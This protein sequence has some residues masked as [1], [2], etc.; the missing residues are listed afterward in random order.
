MILSA[1]RY[2]DI[3]K[4]VCRTVIEN[5]N[6]NITSIQT[7]SIS[8]NIQVES[9]VNNVTNINIST[10]LLNNAKNALDIII[11]G[12]GE[13]KDL[14]NIAKNSI[15]KIVESNPNLPSILLNKGKEA[16]KNIMQ[17]NQDP[18]DLLNIAKDTLKDIIKGNSNQT[19]NNSGNALNGNSN[20]PENTKDQSGN[21]IGGNTN[22]SAELLDNAKGAL[23]NIIKGNINNPKELLNG[24]KDVLV[25]ILKG[26]PNLPGYLVDTA[27]NALKD[28]IQGKAKPKDLL[29]IAKE[30]LKN[31]I[32]VIPKQP[33]NSLSETKNAQGNVVNINMNNPG[34]KAE[35]NK[36]NSKD[37]LNGIGI[38]TGN[39]N[40][41]E[42]DLSDVDSK[43][44]I[45]IVDNSN[46]EE[47]F[48]FVK[49]NIEEEKDCN[50]NNKKR[51]DIVNPILPTLPNGTVIDDPT[52]RKIDLNLK[53]DERSNYEDDADYYSNLIKPINNKSTQDR[54]RSKILFL[55]NLLIYFFNKKFMYLN[56]EYI[57]KI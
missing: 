45:P 32:L 39:T 20:E 56:L 51:D 10:E 3:R 30:A 53:I 38:V 9:S 31:I 21:I 17:G 47:K 57:K 26:N 18:K 55:L 46:K 4:E 25:D 19:K 11:R 22:P 16:L 28:L 2:E 12:N 52:N 5:E 14:L 50:K 29:N 33:N 41:F 24:A 35:G 7:E 1:L 6:V 36:Y 48:K 23:D 44:P 8:Q 15:G 37:L 43:S 54:I 40:K 34:L 49:Q 27:K 42:E 13:S